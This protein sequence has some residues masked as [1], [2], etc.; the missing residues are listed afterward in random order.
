MAIIPDTQGPP[1]MNGGQEQQQSHADVVS[2]W[3]RPWRA[4]QRRHS[5][6]AWITDEKTSVRRRMPT[7][8]S[9]RVTSR[10]W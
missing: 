6:S 9:L 10:D 3:R 4:A 1:E 8:V 5:L 2:G 7:T